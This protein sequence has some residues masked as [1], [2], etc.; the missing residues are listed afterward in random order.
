[1]KKIFSILIATAIISSCG[2][3]SASGISTACAADYTFHTERNDDFYR[4]T[5]YEDAH[6][7]VYNY[8]GQNITDFYDPLALP[9]LVSP[10]PQTAASNSGVVVDPSTTYG[11]YDQNAPTGS[12]SG[13]V[14]Y[15]T[16]IETAFTPASELKRSDGSIG[17]LVIPSLSINMKAYD[18]ETSASMSKGVGHFSE[19]SG[20]LGNIGLCGHNRNATYAIGTIKNLKIGD[21]IRYSTVLGTKTYAVSFVGTISSNDWSYLAA[22]TDNRITLITCLADQPT[23]RVC[24]Q[25]TEIR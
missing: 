19:T 2:M 20:W 7:S 11:I 13:F 3:F 25:A 15:N 8:G 23:L 18:G 17:T 10:T 24:V 22:T 4:S 21:T 12:S 9:G 14:T 5:L 1:M 16:P 6:G